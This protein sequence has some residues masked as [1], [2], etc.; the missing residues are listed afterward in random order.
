ME[1][2]TQAEQFERQQFEGMALSHDL[3]EN[4]TLFKAIFEDVDLMQYRPLDGCG[5]FCLIWSAGVV[6]SAV[7]EEHIIR[8]VLKNPIPPITERPLDHLSK[9]VL[10]ISSMKLESNLPELVSALCY[11]DCL[12]L[13][14]G[15]NRG[16]LME[17]KSF[18]SRSVTEPEG[19]KIL[20][21][22]REGFSE[23][24]MENLSMLRRK[25]RTGDLKLKYHHVGRRSNTQIC[26]AYLGSLVKPTVL[27]ELHRRLAA[28]DM[29]AVLDS[30]Y[31]TELIRDQPMSLFRSTGYTERPD[32]VA[33]K[34]LEGRVA[35]F[36]DGTPVVLTVPYLFIEN[37]QSS[38]DYYVN[39]YAATIARLLR[40]FG[41]LLAIVIPGLYVAI[42]CYHQEMLPSTLLIR[43]AVDSRN[44]PF[45]TPL[46]V[47]SLLV[48][49]DIL[50]E[51]GIRM[52]NGVG[53]AMS[54]VGA[55][56]VGSAAVEADLVSSNVIIVTAVS[57]ITT[58]LVPKLSTAVPIL[59]NILVL[60]SAAMGFYGLML[61]ISFLFI[62]FLA[63]ES[64]GV[65]QVD[66]DS[67]ISYQ[68]SKDTLIRGPLWLMRERP[69][70][71]S[72]NRFRMAR[73]KEGTT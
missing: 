34:L 7:L 23:V 12:L 41:F 67:P 60:I 9:H 45:P 2:E 56:V 51:T 66:W 33:A 18:T 48:M 11:G 59:R 71:L 21:G 49:F 32:V 30:H 25:L 10:E 69:N 58:L 73:K 36:V 37:F 54:I 70:G 22:P 62:H 4:T 17:T 14:E 72:D 26:I 29:D 15:D 39:F 52:P 5:R 19:E 35:V 55:L 63:L 46:E 8:S 27:A 47:F 57:G 43:I 64:F 20:S 16:L 50:R 28:I 24:L 65:S 53:Q 61:G 13:A 40:I 1:K 31:L 42:L 38:E 68:N 44:V 3:D 6:N